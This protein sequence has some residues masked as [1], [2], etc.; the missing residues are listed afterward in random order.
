MEGGLFQKGSSIKHVFNAPIAARIHAL[1]GE[2]RYPPAQVK[3][4]HALIPSAKDLAHATV[5]ITAPT[6]GAARHPAI[7]NAKSIKQLS[8][9][10]T[11]VTDTVGLLLEGTT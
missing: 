2:R 4:S 5:F 6:S 10:L 1:I 7:A 9:S 3:T 8:H 11:S